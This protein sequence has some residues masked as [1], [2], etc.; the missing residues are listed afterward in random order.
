M[1]CSTPCRLVLSF[2]AT[3]GRRVN[4]RDGMIKL[5]QGATLLNTLLIGIRRVFQCGGHLNTNFDLT[6]EIAAYFKSDFNSE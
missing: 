5:P 6:D 1:T 3:E 4:I 2:S